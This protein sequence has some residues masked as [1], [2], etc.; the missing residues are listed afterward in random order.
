MPG[1]DVTADVRKTLAAWLTT[2][3]ATLLGPDKPVVVREEWPGAQEVLP[4][5]TVT[6][7]A[8]D[9]PPEVRFWAPVEWD[10]PTES[11]PSSP[12]GTT[13][14]SWGMFTAGL[15]L[16]VW[17]RYAATRT[18]LV[19]ALDD[20]LHRHPQTTLPGGDG[21][22]RAGRWHELALAAAGLPGAVVYYRFAPAQPPTEDG[23]AL[24]DG[25]YRATVQGTAQGLLTSEE[26][27]VI[28][29]NLSVTQTVGEAPSPPSETF[30]VEP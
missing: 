15:Q 16:D 28:M 25:E 4:E 12:T 2:E 6:V 29:R 3:L 14:Y 26:A 5:R 11:A 13:R 17:A 19:A 7:L 24:Q 20:A 27:C 21:F 30:T 22:P 10:A 18:E 9:Q 23:M 8:V 1:Y